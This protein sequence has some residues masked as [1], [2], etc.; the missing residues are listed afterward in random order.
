[1]DRQRVALVGIDGFSP[2]WM[3]RF[4]AAGQLPRLGAIAARGST[5]ALRSTLPATTPVAWATVATGCSP[6]RT[7]IDGNL[8]HRRGDRLDRRLGCYAHRCRAEPLWATACR[9]GRRSYVVKFPVSYPSATAS[10]RLDGA[11]GWAG[12]KCLHELSSAA[13][14]DT[15]DG[16]GALGAVGETDGAWRGDAARAGPPLWRGRWTM[17]SLWGGP[18]L[19]LHVTVEP[20]PPAGPPP[21]VVLAAAPDWERVLARLL[22]GAWSEPLFVRATGRRGDASFAFRVKVLECHGEPLRLRL[23]HTVVHEVDGHSQPSAIWE[24]YRHLAGPIEEQTD[25]FVLFA[26]GIDLATQ[27]ELFRLNAE[28]LQRVAVALLAAEP[29]DL[30]MVQLH[31]TDWAHHMLEG[32]LDSRHPDFRPENVR[33]YEDALLATYR[34]ADEVVGEIQQALAPEDDLVVLGDHGQD[35]HHTTLHVNEWLAGLGLLRWQGDGDE[36]DWERTQAY[37]AGNFIYLNLAGREPSGIVPPAAAERLERRLTAGLLALEDRRPDGTAARPVL[38]AGGK[39]QFAA[40]GTG[41]DG[42]GDVVFLCRSGYQSRNNRGP[43]FAPTRLL[44]EFTSAHDHF[45]PLDPKIETRLF[46]A[47]PSFKTG[48]RH[49]R[50]ER[51]MDVAPT[52]CAALGVEPSPECEGRPL[53]ELLRPPLDRLAGGK[54]TVSVHAPAP[55]PLPAGA[56]ECWR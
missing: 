16:S 54:Q 37:A 45:S 26:G 17:D 1:M 15:A 21:V 13:A 48:Y 10:F 8:I 35:L 24:R 52:I 2:L 19:V 23:F 36:V 18:P 46:A 51:L 4:L 22:P 40:L 43:L 55:P 32:G 12:L 50:C 31:F 3:D 6:V 30:F 33:R 25:P 11:A 34:L 38:A 39:A 14:A 49:A 41:G 7:G 42:V 47:G 53:A 29:W 56:A 20:P 9:G 5:A 44:H 27:L 28:W